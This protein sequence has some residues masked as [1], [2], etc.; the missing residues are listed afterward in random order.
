MNRR[1]HQNDALVASILYLLIF[2]DCEWA[3]R[4]KYCPKTGVWTGVMML[5]CLS[6]N[7]KTTRQNW[8]ELNFTHKNTFTVSRIQPDTNIFTPFHILKY[9]TYC[10]TLEIYKVM[11]S[12]VSALLSWLHKTAL[13]GNLIRRYILQQI[14]YSTH[15][16]IF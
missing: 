13:I 15:I 4:I 3:K 11:V 14:C 7:P 12:C 8:I 6:L 2:D 5:K 10:Q 9:I 16:L 1:K